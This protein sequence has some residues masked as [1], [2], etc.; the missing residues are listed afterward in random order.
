MSKYR[1]C[2]AGKITEEY[3]DKTITTSGWVEN[4]RDHGGVIF[5]DLRDQFGVLQLVSNDEKMFDDL[6]KESSICVKGLI[7]K[8]DEDDYN[9]K[10]AT[11]T[12]ELLFERTMIIY[13]YITFFN[14]L[15][16]L[17]VDILVLNF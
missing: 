16:V 9:E 5:V 2:Y 3:I 4:I 7:R 17:E 8:R 6:K 11:G 15:L 14:I 1:D 13:Y 10:I 12:I